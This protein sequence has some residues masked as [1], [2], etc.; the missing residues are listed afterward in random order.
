MNRGTYVALS[1]ALVRQQMMD[2]ISHNLANNQTVG[3]KKGQA[4]FKI[5]LEQA[6]NGQVLE[7]VNLADIEEGFTDFSQGTL[8]PSG[9]PT[10]MAIQG[11]GFFK[12]Q[13]NAGNI[14][15]TRQGSMRLDSE[16]QL[17]NQQGMVLLGD[18][19]KPIT[20]SSPDIT[21]TEDGTVKTEDGQT[22]KIPLYTFDDTSVLTRQGGG[23][24][25]VPTGEERRLEVLVTDPH[26]FQG[27]LEGS[28]VNLMQEMSH[29]VESTRVFEACQ[30]MLK[31]YHSLAGEAN[32]LGTLG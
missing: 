24:F 9:V 1:G 28:N 20:L 3:F 21:I 32:K 29:M 12:V 18:D 16:G 31:T 11:E 10:H 5:M 8:S 25:T 4:V 26:I 7:R 23:Q 22:T 13:D 15:Y 6:Q 19:R 17:I 30:K 2:T 14:Y 27:Q